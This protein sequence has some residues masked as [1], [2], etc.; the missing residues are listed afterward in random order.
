MRA[1]LLFF[2]QADRLQEAFTTTQNMDA[3]RAN[4]EQ[5]SYSTKYYVKKE[6]F[7]HGAVTEAI[8]VCLYEK[9]RERE[10]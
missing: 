6:S 8:K 7:G 5:G 2:L 1:F 10:R 9:E 4:F 3:A